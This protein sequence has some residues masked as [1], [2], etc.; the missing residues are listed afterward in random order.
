MKVGFSTLGCPSWTLEH[1]CAQVAA[2]G[3]D[4]LELRL[5]DDVPVAADVAA[6]HHAR[7]TEALATVEVSALGS[8]VKI[9]DPDA[10]Q[11]ST[12][13][14]AML[15]IAAGWSIPAVRVFGGRIQPDESR[16]D[17]VRRAASVVTSALTDARD[18]GVTITLETHD[19]FSA[20]AHAA[21]ILDAVGDA[22]F[23]AIWDTQHTFRAGESPQEA[24]AALRPYAVEIQLKDGRR[25]DDGGWEQTQLGDGEAR[26]RECLDTALADG[27]DNWL[28]VEWEKHWSPRLPDPEVA[29]PAHRR[30]IS[31][32]LDT[33]SR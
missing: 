4:G 24:W 28:V 11:T 20:G 9:A 27:F 16:A 29:F 14:R 30:T 1:A 6:I 33:Q 19:D 12:D 2:L 7:V 8:S 13:L 23:A 3:Y 25:L 26:T 5:I 18:L 10:E 32:W 21:A 31:A 15:K 17:A 22:R